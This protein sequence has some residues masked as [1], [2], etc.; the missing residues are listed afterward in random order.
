[1]LQ[2]SELVSESQTKSSAVEPIV[3]FEVSHSLHSLYFRFHFLFFSIWSWSLNPKPKS[4]VE[5]RRTQFIMKLSS[6][7]LAIAA[8]L[9]AIAGNVIAA[10]IPVHEHALE[11]V[12]LFERDVDIFRRG[13]FVDLAA[14]ANHE[15]EAATALNHAAEAQ[16]NAARAWALIG[17]NSESNEHQERAEYLRQLSRD[18]TNAA[19]NAQAGTVS[20]PHSL[21]ANHIAEAERY[22]EAGNLSR[23]RAI[24]TANHEHVAHDHEHVAHGHERAALDH[25]RAA[26]ATGRAAE[27]YAQAVPHTTGDDHRVSVTQAQMFRGISQEHTNAANNARHFG[28]VTPLHAHVNGHITAA[29]RAV[30]AANDRRGQTHFP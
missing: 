8:T 20:N 14:V 3:P 28:A 17:H 29:E 2:H 4:I 24:A 5:Y 11:Q 18:H 21:V 15:R 27:A 13:T 7:S 1:M 25:E 10:P 16:Q 6:I 22:V 9:A 23:D 30:Q 26:D 12:D 19:N